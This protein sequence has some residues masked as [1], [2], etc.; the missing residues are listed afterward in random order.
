MTT[1]AIVPVAPLARAKGRLADLLEPA[2][3]EALMLAMLEGVLLALKEAGFEPYVLTA[4]GAVA[5][6]VANV[7][8]VI[9]E[10][11]ELTGLNEQLERA[12]LTL[13]REEVLI[14]LADLPLAIGASFVAL[15]RQLPPPPSVTLVPSHDGGTNVMVLRPPGRFRLAYGADSARRHLEAAQS[16]GLSVHIIEERFLGVDFDSRET[17]R[18]LRQLPA[19]PDTPAVRLLRAWGFLPDRDPTPEA[20]P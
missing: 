11:P 7:A 18:E 14:A 13:N 2:R 8:T 10:T 20:G 5:K 16:A 19:L 6:A 9:E 4:E 15:S 3:R 17:L 1:A 12:I